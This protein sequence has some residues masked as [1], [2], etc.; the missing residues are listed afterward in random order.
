MKKIDFCKIRIINLK[1]DIIFRQAEKDRHEEDH[2][3]VP[4][5]EWEKVA[6]FCDFNKKTGH[7]RDLARLRGLMLSLKQ[8][9][10]VR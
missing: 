9:P 3:K 8:L 6:K 7:G 5:K 10:L 1:I 2:R 4:G